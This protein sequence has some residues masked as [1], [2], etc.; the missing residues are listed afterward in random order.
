MALS[1]LVTIKMVLEKDMV[2]DNFKMAVN[3]KVNII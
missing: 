2:N 1:L 3:L